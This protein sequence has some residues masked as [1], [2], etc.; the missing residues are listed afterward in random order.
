MNNCVF[1]AKHSLDAECRQRRAVREA[2]RSHEDG[3]NDVAAFLSFEPLVRGVFFRSFA[4]IWFC[5][6]WHAGHTY[7]S[8]LA[9]SDRRL[10]L[11]HDTF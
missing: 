1:L 4:H 2:S 10:V 3:F 9:I 8:R 6:I 7:Q 5:P 11:V